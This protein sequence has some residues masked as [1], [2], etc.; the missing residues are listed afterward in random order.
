MRGNT[1]VE[2][3]VVP[4]ALARHNGSLHKQLSAPGD[5]PQRSVGFCSQ[6]TA[7]SSL[8]FRVSVGMSPVCRGFTVAE[9]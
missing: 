8:P 7:G 6:I 4:E 9:A 3:G 2:F 5:E 1:A